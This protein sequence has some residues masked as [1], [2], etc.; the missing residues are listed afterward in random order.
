MSTGEQLS[1]E[2]IV[3][4]NFSKFSREH[5]SKS[6][7]LVKRY[8]TCFPVGFT[9][10]F[11]ADL[12]CMK[13]NCKWLHLCKLF[14]VTFICVTFEWVVES[15]DELARFLQKHHRHSKPAVKKTNK[16]PK[17]SHWS[18]LPSRTALS[19]YVFKSEN[20]IKE[21]LRKTAVPP[22]TPP[23]MQYIQFSSVE[24]ALVVVLAVVDEIDVFDFSEFVFIVV[25]VKVVVTSLVLLV[26]VGAM[27]S[28]YQS[29]SVFEYYRKKSI[30]LRNKLQIS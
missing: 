23:K 30:I 16:K 12:L 1:Q 27:N 13:S 4:K 11:I 19:H 26:V 15:N 5:L 6:F 7:F 28:I 24:H 17:I 29:K 9:K 22:P 21:F 8:I 20:K 14:Y 10:C 3:L 25:V 2:T 18:Y